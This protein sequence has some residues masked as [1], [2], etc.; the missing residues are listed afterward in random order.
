M[1]NAGVYVLGSPQLSVLPLTSLLTP[2][3]NLEGMTAVSLECNLLG[4][5][6][7]STLSAIVSTSFDLTLWR[8]IARFDF[9]T[10]S[11]VKVANLS[12]LLSKAV[13]QYADLTVEGVNDGMLGRALALQ[14]VRTGTYTAGQLVV[15]ASVR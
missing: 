14:I 6:G 1:N 13:A 2:I 12:G 5:A 8:N 15:N 10:G 3:L 11:V 9:T 7:G 4:A